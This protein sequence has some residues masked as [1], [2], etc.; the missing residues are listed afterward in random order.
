MCAAWPSCMSFQ[1]CS[2]LTKPGVACCGFTCLD[3]GASIRAIIAA[4][5]QFRNEHAKSCVRSGRHH[6]RS[7]HATLMQVRLVLAGKDLLPEECIMH[8]GRSKCKVE[9]YL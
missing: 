6:A 8:P 4:I 1:Q 9:K 2:W 5:Q 7:V 3:K